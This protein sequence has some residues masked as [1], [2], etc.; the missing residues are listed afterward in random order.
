VADALPPLYRQRAF[1]ALWSAQTISLFGSAI[2]Q[3][4]IPLVAVLALDAS[5]FDVAILSAVDFVP[6]LLFTLYAGVVVDRRRRRPILIAADISR[7]IVLATVPIA[8]ALGTLS[9][10]QLY[11]VGFL[12]GTF[13]VFF[14]I[15]YLSY[16]PAVV[17]R[18]QLVTANARL[19]TSQA[20]AQIGGPGIAGALIS[21]MGAPAAVLADVASFLVSALLLGRVTVAEAVAL[22]DQSSAKSGIAASI[23]LGLAYLARQPYLRALTAAIATANLFKTIAY[24]TLI[25]YE[26]RV[27]GLTPA[28]IGLIT[29][30]GYLGVLAGSLVSARLA[31][32]VGVGHAVILAQVVGAAST[33]VVA[34]ATPS[35]AFVALAVAGVLEGLGAVITN[36]TV[37]SLRQAI[38]PPDMVGRV[39]AS[40]RFVNW[41][42]VPVGAVVGGVFATAVGMQATIWVGAFGA[43]LAIVPLVGSSVR[44]LRTIP[45]ESPSVASD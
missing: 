39:N 5:P 36:V 4:A 18:D 8:A 7:A 35:V 22:P 26:V 15:G 45:A 30:I 42:I 23:R 11:I 2:T 41:G 27:L 17:A 19:A 32:L 33:F 14:D 37:V 24:A 10:S 6:S 31:S 25:V 21:L 9:M 1:R 40:M 3:L 13:T 34:V 43:L 38:A 29:A 20:A 12:A 28:A 44:T 16:L